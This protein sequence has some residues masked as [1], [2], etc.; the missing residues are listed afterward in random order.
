M[1]ARTLAPIAVLV[2]LAG[3]V[4]AGIAFRPQPPAEESEANAHAEPV[5]ESPKKHEP[6]PTKSPRRD[7]EEAIRKGEFAQALAALTTD[8]KSDET[9]FLRGLALEG[10]KKHKEAFAA[11]RTAANPDR[12]PAAWAA[13]ALGAARVAF[14]RGESAIARAWLARV[15]LRT[16]HPDCRATRAAD[17]CRM[18]RARF[19]AAELPTP[20]DPD[21]LDDAAAAVAPF[22]LDGPY[23]DWLTDGWRAPAD[24]LPD[25]TPPAPLQAGLRVFPGKNGPLVSGQVSETLV[26]D[27]LQTLARAAGWKLRL[28]AGSQSPLT[29]AAVAVSVRDMALT[30]VLTALMDSVGLKWQRAGDT[31]TVRAADPKADPNPATVAVASL[32]KAADRHDHP[33]AR[34]AAIRVATLY[35]RLGRTADATARYARILTD[36]PHA[37]EALHAGY[38]LGLM[39]LRAGQPAAARSTFRE[40]IDRGGKTRWADLGWWWTG[41]AHLDECDPAAAFKPLRAALDG[42]ERASR[43]AAT[44]GI[45]LCHLLQGDEIA[46]YE[47]LTRHVFAAADPHARLAKLFSEYLRHATTPS[48]GRAESLFAAVGAAEGGKRLGPAGTYFAGRVYRDLGLTRRTVALYDK[49]IAANGPWAPRMTLAAGELLD[50]E[51]RLEEARP[52]LLAV[53]AVDAGTLG[54]RAAL[55]LA[56]LELRAGHP[57]DAL[58]W[59]RRLLDRPDADETTVLHLMGRAHEAEGEWLRAATCFAGRRPTE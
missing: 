47:T 51:D 53:A 15:E 31:L 8:P 59:C 10:A 42:K 29:G 41:R 19:D 28:P 46:A 32:E 33:H 55:R 14:A 20:D 2:C 12:D 43:S 39:Q 21:P 50:D 27:L 58:G 30:D 44:L 13:A 45:V 48:R 3:G 6:E 24:E 34:A 11:Y 5:A 49:A 7:A 57:A 36:M 54:R 56:D 37:R 38:N 40:V 35:E 22:D 9:G 52:R 4:A 1:S 23:L 25:A 26:T 17:E 16:G 18:L